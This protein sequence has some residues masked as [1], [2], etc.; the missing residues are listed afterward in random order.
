MMKKAWGGMISLDFDKT[1]YLF[2]VRGVGSTPTVHHPQFQYDQ[3]KSGHVYTNEQL[4]CNVS[5]GKILSF[6]TCN[7]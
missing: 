3:L 6:D 1:E 7:F 5:T 4:L 2:I